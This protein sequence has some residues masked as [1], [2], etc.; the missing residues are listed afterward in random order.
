[1]VVLTMIA[2]AYDFSLQQAGII[3]QRAKSFEN[4]S[5]SDIEVD[6]ILHEVE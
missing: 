6:V 5:V 1:M 3:F 2:D 4:K